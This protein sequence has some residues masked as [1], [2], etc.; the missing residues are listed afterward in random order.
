[1]SDLAKKWITTMGDYSAIYLPTDQA[2]SAD[3][4]TKYFEVTDGVVLGSVDATTAGATMQG[5][6]DRPLPS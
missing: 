5:Y 3:L 6:I 1:M 2:L 4:V